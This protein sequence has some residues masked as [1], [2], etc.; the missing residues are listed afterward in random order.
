MRESDEKKNALH[1]D[2]YTT[3]NIHLPTSDHSSEVDTNAD[4]DS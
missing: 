1:S 3:L 4:R 2:M